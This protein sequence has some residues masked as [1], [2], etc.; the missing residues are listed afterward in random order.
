L[1]SPIKHYKKYAMKYPTYIPDNSSAVIKLISVSCSKP[2]IYSIAFVVDEVR[3]T[4]VNKL[5]I[6]RANNEYSLKGQEAFECPTTRID[7]SILV[8]VLDEEGEPLTG[9]VIPLFDEFASL[10]P[11]SDPKTMFEAQELK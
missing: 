7:Q 11:G 9:G 6:L 3:T 10:E 8:Y 1:V 4:I 5:K 2:G